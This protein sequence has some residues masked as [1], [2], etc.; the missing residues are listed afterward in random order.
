MIAGFLYLKIYSLMHFIFLYSFFVCGVLLP[1][2]QAHICYFS[3]DIR[4]ILLVPGILESL[5]P[6]RLARK[7]SK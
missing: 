4:E 6:Q 7:S 5:V 1:S 3:G 2:S